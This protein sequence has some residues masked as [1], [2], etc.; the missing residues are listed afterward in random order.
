MLFLEKP[1]HY[2]GTPK[3]YRRRVRMSNS[4][5][6]HVAEGRLPLG[7]LLAS[8]APGGRRDQYADAQRHRHRS[9]ALNS[10]RAKVLDT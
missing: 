1:I 7:D 6:A 2:S 5:F 4:V 9:S 8:Q 3:T 10:L